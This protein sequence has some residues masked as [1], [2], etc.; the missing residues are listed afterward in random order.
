METIELVLAAFVKGAEK[1]K[2]A[3][4]IGGWG[5]AIWCNFQHPRGNG[6]GRCNCGVVDVQTA[7]RQ[8][9]RIQNEDKEQQEQNQDIRGLDQSP[10]N[11]G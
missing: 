4:D 9:Y 5:H 2:K 10:E 3:L 1:Q 6:N 11:Q 7:L 8:Y